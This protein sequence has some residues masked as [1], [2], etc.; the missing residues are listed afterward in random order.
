MTDIK[1]IPFL[2][3]VE[4]ISSFSLRAAIIIA[5]NTR[6]LLV[7]NEGKIKYKHVG[8]HI[9]LSESLS[10]GLEREMLEE[11]GDVGIEISSDP[12]FFDQIW[13]DCNFMI[14]AYF[15]VTVDENRL[16]NISE[17]SKLVS[18]PFHFDE[19]NTEVTYESEIRA[20]KYYLS[21]KN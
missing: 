18:K 2:N 12:L 10:Q 9:R 15:S 5:S 17:T 8:G 21:I 1:K 13:I 16:D 6:V 11:V 3:K 20:L 19:L 7:R 14:N 4:S